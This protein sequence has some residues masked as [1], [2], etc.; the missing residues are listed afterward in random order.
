[1][2]RPAIL[3]SPNIPKPLHGLNPR[4]IMG[5]EAWDALRKKV[6]AS[7]Q[8]HCA[9]CG[10]HKSEAKKHRWL[11]AHETYD[12]DYAKGIA[13]LTEIVPLCH[14][15]HN[16][17]H[18]GRLRMLARS[19]DISAQ[20]VRE[21]MAHGVAVLR[22]QRL[23]IFP[24]TKELCALVSVDTSDLPQT[25][26]PRKMAPWEKWVMRWNGKEYRGQFRTMADWQRAYA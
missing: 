11:E 22:P 6:Y 5:A 9:A 26:T 8:F 2:N 20:D 10:V 21:I 4:T 16:F 19:K 12:I 7:T 3:S 18:S 14:Y 25:P 13:T 24:G 15:C 17:I 23:A 1:M